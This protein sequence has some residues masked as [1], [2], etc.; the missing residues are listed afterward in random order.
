[1]REASFELMG[2]LPRKNS[3][4]IS[5]QN[6]HKDGTLH[7]TEEPLGTMVC[8]KVSTLKRSEGVEMLVVERH[9]PPYDRQNDSTIIELGNESMWQE[10]CGARRRMATRAAFDL[11]T[12]TMDWRE[13]LL[14]VLKGWQ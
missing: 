1:M 2:L 6:E 5:L 12:T 3:T 4:P 8:M 7:R 9:K 10:I 11:T 14:D 13:G